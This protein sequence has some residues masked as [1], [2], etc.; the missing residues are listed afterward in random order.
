[1]M[2]PEPL[3]LGLHSIEKLRGIGAS[4]ISST[5]GHSVSVKVLLYV[6]AKIEALVPVLECCRFGVQVISILHLARTGQADDDSIHP[7]VLVLS[8]S[9][10]SACSNVPEL[11][12]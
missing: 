2:E 12:R 11:L 6:L 5:H 1:M 7:L 3:R 8:A 4:V 10:S 9:I